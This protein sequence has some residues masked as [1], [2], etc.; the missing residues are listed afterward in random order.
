MKRYLPLLILFGQSAI[1]ALS[2]SLHADFW[3]LFMRN[4][5]GLL[6]FQFSFLKLINLKQFSE[7]FRKYDFI[8][9]KVQKYSIIYPFIELSLGVLFLAGFF[10][11]PIS[12]AAIALSVIGIISV[13]IAIKNKLDVKCVC[14]GTVLDVPL[15]TVTLVENLVMGLMAF[16]LFI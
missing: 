14:M 15:S 7:G 13:L 11:K 4:F 10:M 6:F 3:H 5:M 8:A 16:Y 1:A 2:L 12:F 9:K